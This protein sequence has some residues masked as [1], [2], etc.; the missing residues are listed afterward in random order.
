MCEVL[1]H[2]QQK[3]RWDRS[4]RRWEDKRNRLKQGEVYDYFKHKDWVDVSNVGVSHFGLH[5]DLLPRDSLR[6]D[7]FHLRCAITRRLMSNL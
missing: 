1:S 7:V 4:K 2:T 6:F 5:P 3:D